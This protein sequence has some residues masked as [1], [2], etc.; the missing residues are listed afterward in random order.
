MSSNRIAEQLLRDLQSAQHR[1]AE[2]TPQHLAPPRLEWNSSNS[3]T[4]SKVNRRQTTM[5]IVESQKDEVSNLKRRKTI[6]TYGSKKS[7]EASSWFDDKIAAAGLDMIGSYSRKKRKL[8][9]P[10]DDGKAGM[11]LNETKVDGDPFMINS[12]DVQIGNILRR[13]LEGI[14]D[15][16]TAYA[17]PGSDV[18]SGTLSS[19]YV[20][21]G[22]HAAQSGLEIGGMQNPGIVDQGLY[23][24]VDGTDKSQ[25]L[26]NPSN[27]PMLGPLS[28]SLE[29]ANASSGFVVDLRSIALLADSQK[30]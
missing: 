3:P 6:K 22:Q 27:D 28:G 14:D 25:G 16:F 21:D 2:P 9:G 29:Q 23:A 18:N 15:F 24:N 17:K 10:E 11:G 8:E 26:Q 30:E 12:S 20:I 4:I 5:G 7:T 1:L 13:P 19:E